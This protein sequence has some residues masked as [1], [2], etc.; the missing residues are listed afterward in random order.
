MPDPAHVES[1][2]QDHLRHR[3]GA[4]PPER[5]LH[6][7]ASARRSEPGWDGVVRACNGVA[8]PDGAVLSVAHGVLDAVLAAVEEH[9]EDLADLGPHLP[10]AVGEPRAVF[11]AGV[12][13]WSMDPA[14]SDDPGTWVPTDDD[15]VPRW[16]TPFNGDVLLGHEGGVLAAGVGRKQHDPFG[17]EV[18]V[19][20]EE[21]F[22]GRG[23]AQRL[24]TQAAR[25]IL[26]DGAIPLY[27]HA[28][29]NVASAR[30]ADASGFPDVGW[31]VLGLF[32]GSSGTP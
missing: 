30:T 28:E 23:W 15:R 5:R 31:K 20:T 1:R 2:L 14:P 7:V 27:L 32:G 25:R 22:R 4:W 16:L 29:D 19:V 18:A 11:G 13:R 8:T 21:G 12:F 17:H 9:G 24:V 10:A 6:V 26:A 3:Y